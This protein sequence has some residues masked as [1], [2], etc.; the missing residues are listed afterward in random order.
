[1][2]SEVNNTRQPLAQPLLPPD[3]AQ[4]EPFVDRWAELHSADERYLQRQSSNMEELIAFHAA[5]APMLDRAFDYLD[6]YGYGDQLLPEP[7]ARLFRLMLSLAEVA[8]AVEI[9]GQPQMPHT[10]FP[11][12]GPAMEII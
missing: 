7:A 2:D 9:F 8:Q 4:L 1:M 12:Q 6:T 10:S 5:A 3:F 11:H